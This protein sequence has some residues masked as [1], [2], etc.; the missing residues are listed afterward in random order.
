[1]A[2]IAYP[3]VRSYAPE[4]ITCESPHMLQS[5]YHEPRDCMIRIEIE[6]V[7]RFTRSDGGKSMRVLLDFLRE[8]RSTG[9]LSRAAEHAEVSYRHAWNLIEKW[10]E[11]F[12]MPL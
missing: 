12:E 2:P 5:A 1:M 8:I 11:F 7:W 9:K 6:P 4:Y 10:S 3:D